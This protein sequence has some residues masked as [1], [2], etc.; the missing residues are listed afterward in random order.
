MD[1]FSSVEGEARLKPAGDIGKHKP[2]AEAG[3]K[4]K[5]AG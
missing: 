2:P 1:G 5:N 4:E 3:G